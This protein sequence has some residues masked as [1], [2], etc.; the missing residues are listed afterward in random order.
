MTPRINNL[1]KFVEVQTHI[2]MTVR[3]HICC[4]YLHVRDPTQ[5]A[6]LL[7]EDLSKE[8]LHKQ[9]KIVKRETNTSHV[10]QYGEKV[11]VHSTASNTLYS[12]CLL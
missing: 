7:Q 3:V 12:Y 5:R 9:F 1:L 11:T 10:Q 2:G 4:V 6:R 8:T